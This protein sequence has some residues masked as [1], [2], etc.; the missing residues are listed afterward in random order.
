MVWLRHGRHA[1][2][3][4]PRYDPLAEL[5]AVTAVAASQSIAHA[6]SIENGTHPVRVMARTSAVGPMRPVLRWWS[7]ASSST[8]LNLLTASRVCLQ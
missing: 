6:H 3:Q 5:M 7:T 8:S 1:P 2:P 4:T